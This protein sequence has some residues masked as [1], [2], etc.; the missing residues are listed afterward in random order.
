MKDNINTLM[1]DVRKA[2]RNT[3]GIEFNKT[4]ERVDKVRANTKLHKWQK[5]DTLV[6]RLAGI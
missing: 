5:E 4:Q 3:K 2:I 1:K 6:N